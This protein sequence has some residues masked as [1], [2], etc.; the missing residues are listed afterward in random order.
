MVARAYL[1]QLSRSGGLA[2]ARVTAVRSELGGAERRAGKS[3]RDALT[4]LAT[5]LDRDAA[6]AADQAKVRTLVAEVRELAG[7]GR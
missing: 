2:A 1:D 4:R 5:Q 6:S 3:R 7:A